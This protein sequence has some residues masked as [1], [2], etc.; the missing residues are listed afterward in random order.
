MALVQKAMGEYQLVC[1]GR[2]V[3]SLLFNFR[4][5]LLKLHFVASVNESSISLNSLPA[6]SVEECSLR[7]PIMGL[8]GTLG[9]LGHGGTGGIEKSLMVQFF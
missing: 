8:I 2:D 1:Q 5:E 6:I 3:L 9:K 4:F 7:R